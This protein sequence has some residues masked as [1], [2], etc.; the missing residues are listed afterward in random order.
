MKGEGEEW[1]GCIR[2]RR[3]WHYRGGEPQMENEGEERD[4]E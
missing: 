4:K 2:R 1:R 3:E